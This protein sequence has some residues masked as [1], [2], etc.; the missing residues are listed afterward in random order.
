MKKR[1]AFLKMDDERRGVEKNSLSHKV[2][3]IPKTHVVITRN[4][5]C[6]FQYGIVDL[7]A[8]LSR[9]NFVGNYSRA[10]LT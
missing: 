5:N 1:T 9:D 4:K 3:K 2:G 8:E 7:P 10:W 6:I